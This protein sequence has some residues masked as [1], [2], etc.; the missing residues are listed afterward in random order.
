MRTGMDMLIVQYHIPRL[1]HTR[2]HAHIC[3]KPGI[4]QQTRRG[5][6]EIRN[7]ALKILCKGRI[8]V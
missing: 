8:A 2:Q 7:E 6:M 1:R 5:I 3:I 4:K